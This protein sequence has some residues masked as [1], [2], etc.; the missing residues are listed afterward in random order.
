M[1]YE[2]RISHCFVILHIN[3]TQNYAFLFIQNTEY[4]TRGYVYQ[5]VQKKW[6]KLLTFVIAFVIIYERQGQRPNAEALKRTNWT[7]KIKQ[8]RDK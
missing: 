7:L 3:I 5:K 6:K 8:R 4:E 1:H 2:L